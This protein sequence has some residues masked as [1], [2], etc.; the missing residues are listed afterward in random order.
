MTDTRVLSARIAQPI[1]AALLVTACGHQAAP[2]S[3]VAVKV[4]K[5]EITVLQLN[6]QLQRL[7][8]GVP[9]DQ[10]DEA[11]R[12]VIVALIDQQLMAQQAIEHKL[13]REPDVL[14]ALE[15][16]RQQLLAQA[17]VQRVLAAQAKP[18]DQ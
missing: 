1:C 4:N 8:A 18:S 13:D 5:D 3:Q 6:Q 10:R 16:A 2:S 11:T 15:S 12:R 7:P 17:Y 9:Q 14:S